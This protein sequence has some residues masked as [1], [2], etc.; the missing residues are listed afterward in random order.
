MHPLA[1]PI[2]A[3]CLGS[4]LLGTGTDAARQS[5]AP[6]NITSIR[7]VEFFSPTRVWKAHL[8]MT[9]EAWAAMQPRNGVGGGGFGGFGGFRFLGPE[10]GRNG[11]AARQGFQFDYVGATPQTAVWTFRDVAARAAR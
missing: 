8:S 6:T 2:V 3:L 11:V 10:G 4:A 1:R 9:A 5:A 7:P